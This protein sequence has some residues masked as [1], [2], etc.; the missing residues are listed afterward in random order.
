MERIE[1]IWY[2]KRISWLAFLGYVGGAATYLF[3]QI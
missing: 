3:M 1:F 2:V